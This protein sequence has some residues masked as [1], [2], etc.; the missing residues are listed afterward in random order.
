MIKK[1]CN[2]LVSGA[3]GFIGLMLIKELLAS[4]HNVFGLVRRNV[5][6]FNNKNYKNIIIE[7]ISKNIN[8]NKNIR[9]DYFYH[10]AAKTHDN[11]NKDDE[12]YRVNV[13]GLKNILSYVTKLEIKK[14]IMLSS[15]KVKPKRWLW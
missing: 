12:Y 1:K 14:I 4:G 11:M 2:I 6:Y 9:I 15:I 7:D 13:L 10:L 5:N 8:F 3:S